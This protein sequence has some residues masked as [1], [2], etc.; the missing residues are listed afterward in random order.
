MNSRQQNKQVRAGVALAVSALALF[1]V[2]YFYNGALAQTIQ[3]VAAPV[4]SFGGAVTD[5]AQQIASTT[6]TLEQENEFLRTEVARL[7]DIEVEN[8]HLRD[9]LA[10][11]SLV[12]GSIEPLAERTYA[13]PVIARAGVAVY[14]TLLIEQNQTHPIVTGARVYGTDGFV[15]GTVGAVTQHT[16]Q[17]TVLSAAGNTYQA[18]VQDTSGTQLAVSLEGRGHGNFV[19]YVPRDASIDVGTLVYTDQTGIEPVGI[20][21]QTSAEPTDA[22]RTVRIHVPFVIESLRFVR[23]E[24]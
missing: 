4:L 20:V 5:S 15:I 22:V 13:V 9:A 12:S 21:A 3:Q 23:I 16:A 8:K 24:R 1:T 11:L 18:T 7:A 10:H 6:H 17:V 2:N 19:A 14:G